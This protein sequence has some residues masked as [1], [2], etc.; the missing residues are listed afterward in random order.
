MAQRVVERLLSDPQ[1]VYHAPDPF[2]FAM[3]TALA[4]G[5]AQA[6]AL[7]LVGL[8]LESARLVDELLAWHAEQ[9]SVLEEPIQAKSPPL[10][11]GRLRPES[12][13]SAKQLLQ[14]QRALPVAL[15]DLREQALFCHQED[16]ALASISDHAGDDVLLLQ[17][18]ETR[19]S[20]SALKEL[21]NRPR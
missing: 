14:L 11:I 1:A 9:L 20:L 10:W 18:R 4:T 13:R 16:I 12:R 7:G 21:D 2:R 6:R 5:I 17:S 15:E 3:A 8:Q 19:T